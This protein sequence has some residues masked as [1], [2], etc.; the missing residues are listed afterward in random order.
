MAHSSSSLIL[1]A[2]FVEPL[3]S[4]VQVILYLDLDSFLYENE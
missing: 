2:E 4:M 3:K 1:Y